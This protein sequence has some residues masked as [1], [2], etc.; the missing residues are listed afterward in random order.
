MGVQYFSGFGLGVVPDG[1]KGLDV[2]FSGS[3]YCDAWYNF[4]GDVCF[5]AG[6]V[7]EVCEGFWGSYQGIDCDAKVFGEL[8][9][10]CKSSGCGAGQV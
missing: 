5:G 9:Q 8:Y 1:S 10:A 6:V 7:P 2:G 4:V 3:V